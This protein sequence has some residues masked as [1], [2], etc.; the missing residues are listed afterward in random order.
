MSRLKLIFAL[1]LIVFYSYSQ[2]NIGPVASYYFSGNANDTISKNIGL[3]RGASLAKDRFGNENSAYSFDGENDLINLGA[4]TRLKQITMSISLWAKINNFS[5]NNLNYSNQ[6]FVFTRARDSVAFY[7]AYFVGMYRPNQKFDAANTSAMQKQIAS[8]SSISAEKEKWY[9]IVYMFDTDTTYL[10][11]NG[12][13]EQKNYKGF[14]SSYLQ[15]DSVVLGYVGNQNKEKSYCWLNGCL[16]DLKFYDRILSASEVSALYN[17]P[18]P[19]YGINS[20]YHKEQNSIYLMFLKFWYIPLFLILFIISVFFILKIRIRAIRKRD[21]EKSDLQHQ[22][23]QMEMQALRSQMNPHF[24]FN[25]INS[26][27]H[28]VLTSE[29]ELANKYL[30]KFARLMRN[31]LE[32]SKQ[33]LVSLKKEL[34][35]I[36]LYV[37]IESLRFEN[38]FSFELNI[39]KEIDTETIF[40][41]PL[42]IQPFVE[43]AIWHGLLLKEGPKRLIINTYRNNDKLILEIED[44]GIGRKASEQF[45]SNGSERKS[46]GIELTQ[47]RLDLL[48]KAYGISISFEV[49]DKESTSKEPL[50]T[51]VVIVI[52][53]KNKSV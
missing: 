1:L 44:N 5:S 40:I 2:D 25:A 32:L 34:E 6:P 16:D 19:L 12:K 20:D 26:I 15:K 53:L 46:F 22:L 39:S 38:V 31:V 13:L 45:K 14:F 35:T 9:H 23:Q 28:Y 18:N 49:I 7:E 51:K 29:K 27:Q 24:I 8:I 33:E 48:E 21:K 52:I 4:N 42:I 41:P 17:E 30:V 3:V 11:V 43:N 10:F 50:G 37:E 47:S 36:N